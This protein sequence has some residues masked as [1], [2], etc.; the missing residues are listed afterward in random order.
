MQQVANDHGGYDAGSVTQGVEHPAGHADHFPRGGVGYHAEAEVAEA[1]AEERQAHHR[2]HQPLGVDVVAQHHGRAQ[3]HA[4][5]DRGLT[6][7]AQGLGAAQQVVGEEARRH[8][9][10]QPA[11]GRD[12]SHQAGLK[13]VESTLLDQID[14]EPSDIEPGDRADA[15]LADE[16]AQQHAALEQQA[17]FGQRTAALFLG[18]RGLGFE[19]DQCFAFAQ[20][21][22]LFAVHFWV[23]DWQ[24]IIFPPDRGNAETDGAHDDEHV[25]PAEG[26]AKPTHE[27]REERQRDVL[28]AVEDRPGHTPLRRREPGRD[29]SCRRRSYGGLGHAQEKTQGQQQRH[30]HADEMHQAHAHREYRPDANGQRHGFLGTETVSQPTRRDQ[31]D[32]VGPTEDGKQVAHFHRADAKLLAHI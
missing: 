22:Q 23:A 24:V 18:Q 20:V 7:D 30:D 32:H 26:V 8:R 19:V 16:H 4:C 27:G 9:T 11:H 25:L 21:I 31:A 14:G 29:Y 5:D 28:R 13:D 3:Q 15:V 6:G 2:N 1:L 17:H 12:R 10:D